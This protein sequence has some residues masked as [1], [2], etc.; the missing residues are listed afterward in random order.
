MT[1]VET[2]SAI[3]HEMGEARAEFLLGE[4]WPRLL[5]DLARSK[6]EIM[7]RAVRDL[8]ADCLSTLPGLLQRESPAALHFFFGNFTGMRRQLFPEALDSYRR[9]VEGDTRALAQLA[10]DGAGRWQGV[11]QQILALHRQ[12]GAEIG[13]HIEQLLDHPPGCKIFSAH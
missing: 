13:P 10:A 9:W 8:L 6:A 1:E 5:G 3:L 2:E 4:A 11:A 7:V 12:Y